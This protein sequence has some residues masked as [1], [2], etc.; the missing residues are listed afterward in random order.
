MH[1]SLALCLALTAIAADG[2]EPYPLSPEMRL[3]ERDSQ[4]PEYRK[5]LADMLITELAAEWKRCVNPDDADHLARRAGGAS[6]LAKDEKLRSAVERRKKISD[7]YLAV[8]RAEYERRKVK[9]PFDQ[10]AKAEMAAPGDA[11]RSAAASIAVAAPHSDMAGQW[12]RPRGPSGQGN[13]IGGKPPVEWSETKNIVWKTPLPGEGNS[14]PTLW[15]DRIFLTTA[16]DQG[17]VR[18]LMCF[19]KRSGKLLW[20][21]DVQ[22]SPVEKSI[23]GE[24][25]WASS[26]PLVDGRRVYVFLG[27][28]GL[29]ACDL[30]GKQL[31]K[32][33]LGR[34]D[35]MHGPG[36]TPVL[37][38]D[39]VIL[40]Q[41]QNTGGSRTVAQDQS[42]GAVRWKRDR[43]NAMGWCTPV[44]L[45][46]D[47]RDELIFTSNK[48]LVSLDP[49]EGK[50][51]WSL[52]GPTEEPVPSIVYDGGLLFCTSGRNGPTLAVA[53]GAGRATLVWSSP[54]GGPHV[55]SPLVLG[56][57][58]YL[59]N[60][61][62]IVSCLDAKDGST[63]YQQRLKG[64]FYASPVSAGE[65]IYLTNEDGETTVIRS[66]RKFDVVAVNRL[67]GPMRASF[68][69]VDG[70]IYGRSH[71]FLYCLGANDAS[72]ASARVE[73]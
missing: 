24:N 49:A 28:A 63:I 25:G 21:H 23:R 26:T 16:G 44:V 32:T 37:Y 39:L 45:T 55:P 17:I 18:S 72:S 12:H 20:R 56:G 14:S 30:D 57:A 36:A 47:G 8:V 64:K 4:A 3:I 54:R 35:G 7:D 27:N 13:A 40:V 65:L 70:R 41:D 50:D 53:P 34:F 68:A 69:V 9:A 42:T 58:I 15:N 71:Q 52:D 11:P 10:G 31:W 51:L 66:G 60:D 46:I 62:G 6:A 38:R 67:E 33:D 1:F 29:L 2:D 48:K 61:R 43:P 22:A 73:K 5:I 59:L 19:D